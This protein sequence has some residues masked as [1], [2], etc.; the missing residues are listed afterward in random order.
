MF[1]SVWLS[2]SVCSACHRPHRAALPRSA[3]NRFQ[4]DKEEETESKRRR[5]VMIRTMGR[6]LILVSVLSLLSKQSVMW[7]KESGNYRQG[8]SFLVTL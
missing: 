5:V 7:I 2:Q 8:S 6:P 3:Y 4:D 1:S